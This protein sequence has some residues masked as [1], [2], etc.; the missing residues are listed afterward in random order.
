MPT[1]S[2]VSSTHLHVPGYGHILLDAGE[3]TLGQLTRSVG[4][5]EIDTV[6]RELKCIFVS[7]MHADH[8]TGLIRLLAK[9]RRV[10]ASNFT[11]RPLSLFSSLTLLFLDAREQVTDPSNLIYVVAPSRIRT[12][13]SEKQEFQ[14]LGLR[15]DP[16][17]SQ[18][19]FVDTMAL[20]PSSTIP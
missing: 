8:H 6:L 12:M 15:G 5:A 20:L 3:G 17:E 16:A 18:I 9:R 4:A 13:I 1:A 11:R 19:Q 14:D 7:H 10:R 2:P